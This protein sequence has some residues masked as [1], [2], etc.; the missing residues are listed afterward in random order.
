M[1]EHLVEI[2]SYCMY[3]EDGTQCE[4]LLMDAI[5]GP[6]LHELAVIGEPLALE[7]QR[8]ILVAFRQLWTA[9]RQPFEGAHVLAKDP[10]ERGTKAAH[11]AAEILRG[12]Q[13]GLEDRLVV[14]GVEIG[15]LAT[16]RPLFERYQYPACQ[17]IC[18]QDLVAD[19]FILDSRFQW[20]AIDLEWVGWHD[21]RSSAS[22]VYAWWLTMASEGCATLR[23][24]SRGIVEITYELTLTDICRGLQNICLQNIH[25]AALELKETPTWQPM[26]W[27]LVGNSLLS[28]LRF[29]KER[30]REQFALP[31]LCEGLL[32]LSRSAHMDV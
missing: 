18:Q 17:V 31:L 14:N 30:G 12:Y 32:T 23:R 4:A 26:F 3:E 20:Y 11:A 16:L 24:S 2:R 25:A 7:V 29:S 15:S 28:Q 27:L 13:I 9:S 19:N 6:S 21:W 5:M 22:R 1:P 8:D 10:K